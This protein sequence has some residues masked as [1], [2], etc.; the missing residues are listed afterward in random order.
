MAY[1][2]TLSFFPL[3]SRSIDT[4]NQ[5]TICHLKNAKQTNT[6]CNIYLLN[7]YCSRIIWKMKKSFRL[8]Y[9]YYLKVSLKLKLVHIFISKH[10]SAKN[11]IFLFFHWVP[12]NAYI[13][14]FSFFR[15]FIIFLLFENLHNRNI[16]TLRWI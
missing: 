7:Y 15:L 5:T 13:A 10:S 14:L 6:F 2:T 1:W 9:L 3:I 12:W 4:Y 11:S 16:V 8:F